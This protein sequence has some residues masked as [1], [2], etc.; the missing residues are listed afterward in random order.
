MNSLF[1]Q[2]LERERERERENLNSL[3]Y[4][5]KDW[6]ERIQKLYF[7]KDWGQKDGELEL[8]NFI[9]P[10]TGERE[11]A[12]TQKLYFPRIVQRERQTERERERARKLYFPRTGERK[13]EGAQWVLTLTIFLD[14]LQS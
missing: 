5:S 10:R 11:R 2:G 6:R 8:K 14:G 9:F 3:L 4:F 13:G 7:S 12:Q 1:F